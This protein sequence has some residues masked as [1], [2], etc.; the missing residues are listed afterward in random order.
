MVLNTLIAQDS[1]LPVL[2]DFVDAMVAEMVA[3]CRAI[4]AP[5]GVVTR[6][7]VTTRITSP[8]STAT[9]TPPPAKPPIHAVLCLLGLLISPNFL[10]WCKIS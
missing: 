10:K 8:W 7:V 1:Y 2:V 6:T 4:P 5:P 9:G 3:S